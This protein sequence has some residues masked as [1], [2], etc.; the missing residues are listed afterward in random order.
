MPHITR[1]H[2]TAQDFGWHQ[3]FTIQ[4]NKQFADFPFS[5]EDGGGLFPT[6]DWSRTDRQ[7]Q[8]HF[9]PLRKQWMKRIVEGRLDKILMSHVGSDNAEPPFSDTIL[10][11]FRADLEDF[12]RHHGHDPDWQV[13]DHQPMCLGILV[14]LQNIMKDRDTSLFPSL[15]EGVKTGFQRDIPPSGVFPTQTSPNLVYNPLSIHLAN[16]QSAETDPALTQSLV[17]DEVAKGWAYKCPGTLEDAQ[18]EFP[19][20]VSIGKLGVATSENRPPRLVVD[21]SV[22]GLNARCHIPERSTLP[23]ATEVLRSFPLRNHS[24][25]LAGFSLDI[26]SAHKRIV[27]HPSERG[28]VGF[29]LNDSIYFIY[30]YY[31]TPFG[32]TFSAAWWSRLGGW[33]LRLF[34]HL[35]WWPHC[36]FL[37]VDDFSFLHGSGINAISNNTL[38]RPLPNCANSTQLAQIRIG[39]SNQLD[40]MGFQFFVQIPESKIQKLKQ[41]I[42]LLLQSSRCTRK[43][44]KKS[45]WIAYVDY[46]VFSSSSHVDSLFIFRP[47]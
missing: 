19:F 4:A 2:I 39:F 12:L 8:D 35:I 1:S 7:E 14:L 20:G 25:P 37:Y 27:L 28:L 42:Q 32:A 3:R 18:Q 10:Q 11:P 43:Q 6:P 13:R 36:G 15:Q 44:I 29:S 24:G 46:K 17:D 33:M 31:V 38:L 9:G 47:F 34:H 26:K 30:F 16:W 40:R 45:Y 23:T 21:S 5:H 41:Y 22:C